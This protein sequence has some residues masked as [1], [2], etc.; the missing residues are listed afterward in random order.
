VDYIS[1][2]DVGQGTLPPG[3]AVG[4]TFN[5]ST[6]WPGG[7]WS[8]GPDSYGIIVYFRKNLLIGQ[9][10]GFISGLPGYPCKSV[11]A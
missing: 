2:F 11:H 5:G 1:V 6:A 7:V 8:A 4:F 10:C 9:Y 3:T